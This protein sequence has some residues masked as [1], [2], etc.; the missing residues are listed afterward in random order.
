MLIE[1]CYYYYYYRAG[2]QTVVVFLAA[3]CMC[4]LINMKLLILP[5]MYIDLPEGH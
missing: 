5:I 1:Y 3:A 4:V 2:S